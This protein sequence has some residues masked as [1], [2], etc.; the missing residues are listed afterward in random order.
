MGS[1]DTKIE[2]SQGI[3]CSL[4]NPISAQLDQKLAKVHIAPAAI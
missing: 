3:E 2:N 4:D 1:A